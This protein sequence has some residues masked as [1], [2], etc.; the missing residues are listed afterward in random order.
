MFFK[1][2]SNPLRGGTFQINRRIYTPGLGSEDLFFFQ[3]DSFEATISL[4]PLEKDLELRY[5]KIV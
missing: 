4:F 1:F 5:E 2:S 3:V